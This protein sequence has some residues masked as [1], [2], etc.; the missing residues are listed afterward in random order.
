MDELGSECDTTINMDVADETGSWHAIQIVCQF[1]KF[2][3]QC[4]L[5]TGEEFH[6]RG[7]RTAHELVDGD[8]LLRPLMWPPTWMAA[9][10][11]TGWRG[12]VGNRV[13][14]G[15]GLESIHWEDPRGRR[16]GTRARKFEPTSAKSV[17]RMIQNPARLV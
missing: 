12:G 15:L 5:R 3:Q 14:D 11:K 2:A 9:L 8:G 4:H 1:R 10:R 13:E 16:L 17:R 6:R 7:Q